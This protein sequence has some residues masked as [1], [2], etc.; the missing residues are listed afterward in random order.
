MQRGQ[1]DLLSTVILIGTALVIGLGFLGIL[2]PNVFD[3]ANKGRIRISLYNEQSLLVLYKEY[4]DRDSFC[5][6]IIRIEPG[7]ISYAITLVAGNSTVLDALSFNMPLGWEL[8]KRGIFQK[9]NIN[10]IVDGEYYPCHMCPNNIEVVYVYPPFVDMCPML[11]CVSKK[12]LPE[13]ITRATLY[14]FTQIGSELYE[15]GRYEVFIGGTV[16]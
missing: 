13:D 4:E 14:I 11:V 12:G 10:I 1:A 7:R 9:R 16:W 5:I 8:G 2:L 15:V 6:G 3:L